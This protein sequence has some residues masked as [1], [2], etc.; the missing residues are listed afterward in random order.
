M[1]KTSKIILLFM[2]SSASV[3]AT[4]ITPELSLLGNKFGISSA[5]TSKIMTFYLSGYLVGQ[6]A[7]SYLANKIGRAFSIRCGMFIAIIGA[8]YQFISFKDYFFPAFVFFRFI[9]ALGLSSGLV[10][11]FTIIKE[12]LTNEDG[13]KYLSFVAIAFTSSVYLSIFASGIIIS[14][15]DIPFLLGLIIAYTTTL[16]FL[17][18]LINEPVKK[19]TT[20]KPTT[21]IK[22]KRSLLD[23][24][25]ISYSLVLS[26]TTIISYCYAFYAPF[27][28]ISTYGLS[29]TTFS[30]L[31]LFNMV[32]I[33]L[34]S[35]LYIILSKKYDE[36][37][38]LLFSLSFVSLLSLSF[39]IVYFRITS[40]PILVFFVISFFLNTCSGLIYPAATYK[41]MECGDCKAKTSAI[42]N[43]IKLIMPTISLAFSS[44][45]SKS[46]LIN[47]SATI[48]FFSL[49]YVLILTF[50]SNRVTCE[51]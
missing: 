37:I 17:S 15:V 20:N 12:S 44:L 21:Q 28:T 14:Y 46:N 9:T 3:V 32:A 33:F 6:G 34:G 51:I 24:K 29:P 2:I 19:G 25:L 40:N 27:V 47:L 23:F 41:A 22:E 18:F 38:I 13:K 50:R 1:T 43:A 49:L 7:F 39:F 5:Q 16:F 10:C 26:I 48:M 30:A 45:I 35:S 42:M 11:G 36:K 4:F 31:N 8:I